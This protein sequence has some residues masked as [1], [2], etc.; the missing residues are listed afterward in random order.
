M[1]GSAFDT[2]EIVRCPEQHL[3]VVRDRVPMSGIPNL[4]DRAFPAIFAAMETAGVKPAGP[5]LGV[6]HGEPTETIDISAAVPLAAPFA[7]VQST[8]DGGG[9]TAETLPEGRAATLFVRG[10]Y[11]Q[12][13]DA[14]AHLHGWVAEQG[15]TPTDLSWE[16]YLTEP[17]P[18]GDPALNETRIYTLLE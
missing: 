8:V 1:T 18:G 15:L 2:P 7:S 5:A 10:D 12:L 13:G 6:T 14:Y 4:F 3:A 17:E 11:A 9:V 16:Q